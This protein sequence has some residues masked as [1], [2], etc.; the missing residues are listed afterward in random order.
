M[1]E[2][3][4]ELLRATAGE[5]RDCGALQRLVDQVEMLFSMLDD[6]DQNWSNERLGTMIDFLIYRAIHLAGT[7]R[8]DELERLTAELL[9]LMSDGLPSDEGLVACDLLADEIRQVLAH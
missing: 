8:L 9:A 7:S 2:S 5:T 3:S 1:S 6:T 4:I